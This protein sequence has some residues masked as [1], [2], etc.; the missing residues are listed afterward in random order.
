MLYNTF[1]KAPLVVAPVS[2]SITG[3][4][5]ISPWAG[6]VWN[7]QFVQ[8]T[9]LYWNWNRR[10]FS[11]FHV[12][13]SLSF[14]SIQ[15]FWSQSSPFWTPSV[16]IAVFTYVSLISTQII[17]YNQLAVIHACVPFS[18]ILGPVF[19]GRFY[20]MAPLRS[21]RKWIF[22]RL[23]DCAGFVADKVGNYKLILMGLTLVGGLVYLP[24]L[25]LQ[26][27]HERDEKLDY[28]FPILLIIRLFGF[29]VFDA[30]VALLDS[31]GMC[32]SKMHGGDFG[33]Q[34]MWGMAS[35]IVIPFVCGILVD[36]ISAYRGIFSSFL[37]PCEWW[38]LKCLMLQDSR[39][40][41]V[42]ST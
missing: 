21:Q 35:L 1:Y 41:R 33:R 3:T 13:P 25:W 8:S 18:S 15:S 7:R 10:T 42:L 2:F 20:G 6:I 31:C 5:L 9:V 17:S 32:M 38:W 40:I 12:S 29:L 4:L 22:W 28:I 14:V 37:V 24:V 30:S 23:L 16:W 19:V 34:K 26:A 39:I 36:Y 27:Q 11:S